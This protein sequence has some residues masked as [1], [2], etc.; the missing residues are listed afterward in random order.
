MHSDSTEGIPL[1]STIGLNPCPD[2]PEPQSA[3][4][5]LRERVKA[6]MPDGYVQLNRNQDNADEF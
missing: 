5:R 6:V 3:L 1:E 4:E 2:T